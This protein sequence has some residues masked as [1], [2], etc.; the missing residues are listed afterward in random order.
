MVDIRRQDLEDFF[1]R[2]IERFEI[3]LVCGV[4]V[5]LVSERCNQIIRTVRDLEPTHLEVTKLD[6]DKLSANDGSL[7]DEA[8]ALSLFGERQLLWVRSGAKN[9]TKSVGELLDSEYI[10]NRVLIEAGALKSDSGLKK[11]CSKSPRAAV[12]ECW[13]D[14]HKDISA[15]IDVEF[16]RAGI[17]LS[18]QGKALLSNA[19][20]GDRLLSR[21]EI[22]KLVLYGQG[23]TLVDVKE[24]S[25]VVS[26]AASWGFDDLV[27]AAFEGERSGISEK[28]HAALNHFD[29]TALLSMALFHCLNLLDARI[30]IEK[31]SNAAAAAERFPRLFGPRRTSII[32]QL[33]RWSSNQLL[34]Q[35]QKLQ[36][37]VA[38]I[39]KEPRLQNETMSRAFL[40]I[41]FTTPK[42]S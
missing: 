8:L 19:L 21:S 7:K 38:Q 28:I 30:E 25:E 34:L 11:L 2:K 36:E 10:E 26:D 6:G 35:T 9:L 37:A 32:S 14:S 27:F 29:A 23:M 17:K 12:I 42:V 20:G 33:S 16:H 39:R 15:L 3:F 22:D 24:V 13:P 5:G 31:G 41:T 40:S 18:D 1:R 4:D